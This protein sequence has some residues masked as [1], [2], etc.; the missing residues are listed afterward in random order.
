MNPA[1]LTE[2]FTTLADVSWRAS[3]FFAVLLLLRFVVR[4]R[5]PAQVWFFVWIVLAVRLLI[6][7]SI[8]T[9]W[10]PYNLGRPPEVVETGVIP[11]PTISREE[12]ATLPAVGVDAQDVA[13]T[14]AAP[15]R[16]RE[17]AA[18]QLMTARVSWE[19]VAAFTWLAG[20][21]ALVSARLVAAARFRS[22]PSRRATRR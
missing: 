14:T 11:A 13:S 10:S 17:P 5:I 12:P 22:T 18:T 20:F 7:V 1:P 15:A 19:E 8:S 2:L 6:P 21:L 16:I 9:S 4:G 3:W